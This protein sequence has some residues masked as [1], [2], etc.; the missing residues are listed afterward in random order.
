MATVVLGTLAALS[1]AINCWQWIVAR[2]FPLHARI[3]QVEY[4]PPVTI[5]KPLRGLDSETRHCIESWFAQNYAAPIQLLFG[6]ASPDDPVGPVIENMIATH[7]GSDARLIICPEL[8]GFNAKVSTL[9]Q[10]EPLARHEILVI[11]D[12]DVLVPADFLANIIAPLH[13]KKVGLVTCFYRLANATTLAMRWEAVGTNADFWSQV[14]QARSLKTLD[15][16]LGAAIATRREQAN[17]IGGFRSLANYVADDYQLGN[18]IVTLGARI[19]I[20]P[21]VVDCREAPISWAQAW[22]HQVRWA[23]TIRFCRPI[24]YF[25]SILGN[26]TLWPLLWLLALASSLHHDPQRQ[27]GESGLGYELVTSLGVGVAFLIVRVLFAISLQVR[28]SGSAKDRAWF[29]LVPLKDLL[30]AAI[31][32]VSFLGNQIEWR[33][34]CYRVV[35]GGKLT[36]L[37]QRGTDNGSIGFC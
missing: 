28:L 14:L 37:S 30:A 29:W 33:G 25:F 24:S 34:R 13:D 17:A 12:A 15:F 35:T 36:P 21:L 26:A 20:S 22:R 32:I 6:V 4:T 16:A 8:L 23:R 31:W 3:D 7:P 9:S 10:L 19:E 1:F 18:R 11:S 5:L 2:R 27:P